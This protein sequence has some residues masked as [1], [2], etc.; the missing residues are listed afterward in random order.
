MFWAKNS[1]ILRSTLDCIY[2]IW[3]NALTLLT[4][5]DTVGMELILNCVTGR[6]QCWCIVPKAYV[7]SEVLLRIGEFV[8]Q[9]M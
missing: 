7:Q 9:N 5:S 8:A 6:Q 2:S 1:P 4:T 3:Y